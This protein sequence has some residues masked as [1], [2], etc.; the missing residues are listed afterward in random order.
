RGDW[1]AGQPMLTRGAQLRVYNV[2]PPI[3]AH[4][5]RLAR[6]SREVCQPPLVVGP[7]IAPAPFLAVDQPLLRGG[8]RV[9]RPAI[10][11]APDRRRIA[12]VIILA[13]V[14]G[15]VDV[16]TAGLA[17]RY[18]VVGGKAIPGVGGRS[19]PLTPA[20]ECVSQ[21]GLDAVAERLEHLADPA[22]V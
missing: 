11:G 9:A 1:L 10:A 20:G 8:A 21:H 15:E 6:G 13:A 2:T 7:D 4:A 14:R 17:W 5:V 18:Q 3:V 22:L 12:P 19:A 16:A